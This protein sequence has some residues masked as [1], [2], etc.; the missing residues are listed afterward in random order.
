KIIGVTQ[1]L[2]KKGGPFTQDDE[3]RLKAFTAQLAI[4]LQNAKL[5]DDVQNMKNYNESMLQSMS[6]G[7]VTLNEDGKIITCNHAGLRIL[8]TAPADIL[9]RTAPEFFTGPNSWILER[10]KVV[11]QTLKTDISMGGEMN[12]AEEKISVNL[13]V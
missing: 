13:T 7:V 5:F 8:R 4:S 11:D 12:I 2:N 1:A 10:I 3:A 6:N 9:N